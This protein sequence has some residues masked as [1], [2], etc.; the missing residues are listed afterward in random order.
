[1]VGSM[2][3]MLFDGVN[4]DLNAATQHWLPAVASAAQRIVAR[5]V[6]ACGLRWMLPIHPTIGRALAQAGSVPCG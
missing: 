6:A 2:I 1:M 5:M 4:D 3:A